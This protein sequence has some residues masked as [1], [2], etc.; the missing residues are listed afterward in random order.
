MSNP[1][2]IALVITL[3]GALLLVMVWQNRRLRRFRAS[4]D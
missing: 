3:T 1:E 4:K 2:M